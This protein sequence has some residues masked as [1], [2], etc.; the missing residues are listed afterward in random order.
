MIEKIK[1]KKELTKALQD[2]RKHY[3][4]ITSA[5]IQTFILGWEA[6]EKSI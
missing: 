1:R 6:A 4:S 3:P 2:F 5:D